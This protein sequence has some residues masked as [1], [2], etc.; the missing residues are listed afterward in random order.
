MN[1]LE[2]MDLEGIESLPKH[3]PEM[4]ATQ[5]LRLP[6]NGFHRLESS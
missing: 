1:V 3:Q 6:F 5:A 4:R 2:G